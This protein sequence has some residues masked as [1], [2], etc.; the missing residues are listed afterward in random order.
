SLAQLRHTVPVNF[1]DRKPERS[2]LVGERFQVEDFVRRAVGLLLVV[3]QQHRQAAEFVL[4]GA[5]NRLPQR[6]FI[7]FT[8]AADNKRAITGPLAA[9]IERKSNPEGKP[10]A[11]AAR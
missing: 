2:P 1:Y 5:Q 10:V 9:G 7:G 11:Q 6:A 4:G 8:V 3:V